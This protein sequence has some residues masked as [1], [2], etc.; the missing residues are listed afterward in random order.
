MYMPCGERE[1]GT[2]EKLKEARVTEIRKERGQSDRKFH[3]LGRQRLARAES[4]G[5]C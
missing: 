1:H 2:Y 3:C 5:P 4:C